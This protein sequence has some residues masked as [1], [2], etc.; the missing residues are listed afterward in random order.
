MA[1]R[2]FLQLSYKGTSYHGWQVQP[3]ALSVQEVMEK[4]LSTLLRENVSVVGAGRT[5]T[6]VHASFFVLHFDAANSD[7]DVQNFP[8]KLNRFLPKDIAVQ[9]VW[10]VKNDAHARFDALS[11]TYKYYISTTKDPFATETTYHFSPELDVLKMNNA[12]K[13][14]FGYTDFTSFSRLHTDVKTNNCKIYQA[15]WTSEG[16]QLVFTIKADRFLR[17]MVRAIVGTLLEVGKGKLSVDGFKNVI[18]AEDR[19]IAGVSAPAEGL[20][21]VGIEYPDEMQAIL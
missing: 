1:Q 5:D 6:G 4:A 9:R 15:E 12:A 17:N 20:F 21:L 2:Y 18:E 16:T 11:R 7:I 14:L 10:R 8:Y 13:L 3:N 19:R